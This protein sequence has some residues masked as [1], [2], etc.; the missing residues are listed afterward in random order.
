MKKNIM[1]MMEVIEESFNTMLVDL[2]EEFS[3]EQRKAY[4]GEITREEFQVI[5]NEISQKLDQI[6]DTVSKPCMN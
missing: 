3:K 5:D 2:V 6:F 4:S 1:N